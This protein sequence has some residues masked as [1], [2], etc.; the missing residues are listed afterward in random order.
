MC[1]ARMRV[2]LSNCL[3]VC[4][5]AKGEA[6]DLYAGIAAA[7]ASGV[8]CPSA[9]LPTSGTTITIQVSSGCPARHRARRGR[10]SGSLTCQM[11][12]SLTTTSAG[13]A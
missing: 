12:R 2:T 11:Q 6:G 3:H 5:Q 10:R 4:V 1:V 8:F 13:V 9:G 7:Y